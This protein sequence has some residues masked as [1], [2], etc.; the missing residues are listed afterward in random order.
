[1]KNRLFLFAIL[2][3][4]VLPLGVYAGG[5]NYSGS[6]AREVNELKNMVNA[7][8]AMI[9]KL[10][11]RLDAL[12]NR[13]LDAMPANVSL[14]DIAPSAVWAE[15]IK[16]KGDFRYRHELINDEHANSGTQHGSHTRNRHRIRAR[17]GVKA[18]INDDTDVVFQLASGSSDPV[19]ANQSLDSHFRSKSVW[20]DLAN[21]HYHPESLF[22]LNSG[23]FDL[24]AGKMKNPFYT[25]GKT[26]LIWDGDLRPEGGAIKYSQKF[27]KTKL[28]AVIGGFWLE[29]NSNDEDANL[30]GFQGGFNVPVFNE[31]IKLV[32]G[33]S[34]Y[35]YGSVREHS[36]FNA[37]GNTTATRERRGSNQTVL[38]TGYDIAEVFAELHMKVFDTPLIVF[39]DLATNLA[40]SHDTVAQLY[41]FKLNKCKK[42]GSWQLKYNWRRVEQD[43]VYGAFTDSDFGGGGTNAKGH[44][45]GF[46]YQLARNTTL[47][48]TL[49]INRIGLEEDGAGHDYTR[50]QMDVKY[51][52]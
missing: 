21:V 27:G 39:A 36:P 9:D 19:S 6:N 38:R 32:A 23:S 8:K 40:T 31:K 42:P 4:L 2:L 35:H 12:E 28:F 51:K 30:W 10:V 48:S 46:A 43:S 33:S 18:K 26:E 37:E 3:G 29:E 20:I 11:D 45:I 52:F 24:Y 50:W 17:L 14:K 13:K 5:G 49:F 34:F 22:G 15:K 25:P 1:M 16:L 7:Q 41:G 47:G 44:E